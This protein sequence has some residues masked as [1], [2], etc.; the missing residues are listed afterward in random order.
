MVSIPIVITFAVY[1][2][3]ILVIGYLA[4]RVTENLA[5]YMLGGRRLSGTVAAFGA[6]ASTA[7]VY[8]N[9]ERFTDYSSIL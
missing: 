9:R 7:C 4:S 8:T 6:G 3:L 2:L 5:D 1:L